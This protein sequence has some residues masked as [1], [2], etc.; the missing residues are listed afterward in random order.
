MDTH[1]SIVVHGE[2]RQGRL[3]TRGCIEN[4]RNTKIQN[5]S[6]RKLVQSPE[7]LHSAGEEWPLLRVY[8]HP[9]P[10]SPT[11]NHCYLI[12]HNHRPSAS[13]FCTII[14]LIYSLNIPKRDTLASKPFLSLGRTT[15][16]LTAD[17]LL[18]V[19]GTSLAVLR[20]MK[21][22]DETRHILRGSKL[23]L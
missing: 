15:R 16:P 21:I 23:R 17:S 19:W 10:F 8:T 20:E 14:D 9:H 22:L 11:R 6:W 5:C 1:N 7:Y 4:S 13:F 18:G 12:L 3:K 2:F